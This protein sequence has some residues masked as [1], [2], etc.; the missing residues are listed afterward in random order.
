MRV[1]RWQSSWHKGGLI[2][3]T[4]SEAVSLTHMVK[5]QALR[6][7]RLHFKLQFCHFL[8]PW[9]KTSSQFTLITSVLPL[10]YGDDETY[11]TTDGIK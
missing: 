2:D 1:K 5:S 9:P 3:L 6:A 8:A 11:F 10:S 7:E 4:E